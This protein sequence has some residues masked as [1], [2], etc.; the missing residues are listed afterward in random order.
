[1]TVA[2]STVSGVLELVN[3][4]ASVTVTA[5]SGLIWIEESLQ[6]EKLPKKSCVSLQTKL[7]RI[8]RSFADL[9]MCNFWSKE[10]V[11]TLQCDEKRAN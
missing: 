4:F 2:S 8:L 11:C 6:G 3:P 7:N 5:V 9:K 1:M 10:R